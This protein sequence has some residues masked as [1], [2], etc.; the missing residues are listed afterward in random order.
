MK[1]K[2]SVLS[3]ILYVC[4]GLLLFFGYYVLMDRVF[5]VDP[6]SM[7]YVILTIYFVYCVVRFPVSAHKLSIMQSEAEKRSVF[8][9]MSVIPQ[10]VMLVA[11]LFAPFIARID[12]NDE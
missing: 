11:F 8:V 1:E 12:L 5:H 4:L 9:R 10:T 2:N 6:L 7:P 3:T